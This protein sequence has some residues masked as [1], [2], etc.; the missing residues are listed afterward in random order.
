MLHLEFANS[1]MSMVVWMLKSKLNHDHINVYKCLL[2]TC[3]WF[4]SVEEFIKSPLFNSPSFGGASVTI[5]HKQAIMPHLDEITPSATKIG[6]VNTIIVENNSNRVLIGDN[7]D[8]IGIYNPIKR[9]LRTSGEGYALILGAGG[10]ARAAA[11]AAQ[12][13]GLKW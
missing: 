1:L 13:L 3:A 6:A 5:P 10:T 4:Y 11:Y 9:L 12:E 2:L 7:T 8:W